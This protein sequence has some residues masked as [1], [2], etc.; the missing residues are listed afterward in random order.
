MAE[1]ESQNTQHDETI[2]PVEPGFARAGTGVRRQAARRRGVTLPVRL[3]ALGVLV[4][5]AAVV[6]VLL[7]RWADEQG[8]QAPVVEEA[9]PPAP[10]EEAGPVYTA[11]ELEAFRVE[12][13]GLLARLLNQQA[14]LERRSAAEWGGDSYET[15]EE[16][17]RQGDDAYLADAFF[18]AAADY[19]DALETGEALLQR[20]LELVEAALAAA[21]A[22]LAAGNATVAAEQFSLILRIEADNESARAGLLR[23]QQLPE[24]LALMQQGEALER[25]GNLDEAVR[26]YRDAVA[27]DGLWA[28]ARS[29]LS[30]LEAQL[31]TRQFE[32]L[33]SAGLGA[34]AAEEYDDAHELFSRALALRPDSRDALDAR[35]QAEQSGKLEQIALVQARAIAFELRERWEDAA[36]LYGDALQTDD[37]LA[38]AQEG[39]KRAQYHVDL[40]LKL[41]NLIENPD[42]L[43]DDGVLR[44]AQRLAAEVRALSAVGP[45]LGEQLE[46]LDGLLRLASTPLPVQ[47][48]S[49]EQT[50]VT[51]YRVGNLGQFLVKELELRPGVYTVVGSRRG[52][53]DVRTTFT[54]IPGQERAPV[55]VECVEPIQ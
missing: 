14:Q 51:L 54:V 39:L 11:A 2:V 36:R 43:F 46:M 26:V 1:T 20:S 23:A 45:R 10:P 37:T 32:A 44:D 42:L 28:P 18:N 27:L 9:P 7:P 16:L 13:D 3:I 31:G 22:A 48:Q 17:A 21:A 38:F 4:A 53:R 19:R 5:A 30:A 52:F 8:A 34:M 12:A 47:L 15:Y 49:D 41:S 40:D 33:M 55:R 35:T 25:S 6:F 24:V 50:E 29:A